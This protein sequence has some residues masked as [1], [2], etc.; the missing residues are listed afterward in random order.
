MPQ[1]V[2]VLDTLLDAWR[3][4]STPPSKLIGTV[5]MTDAYS[6]QLQLLDREVAA[7]HVHR[8]W[9]VG[10]TAASM[11]AERGEA[12]PAPGFLIADAER[13]A[14]P[15]LDIVGQSGWNLEPEL[16]LTIGTPLGAEKVTREAA[17]EAVATA[18]AAFE[19]VHRRSGWE[20]RALQR[21]VN[22]TTSGFILGPQSELVPTPDEVDDAQV[23]YARNKICV[24][25]VRGGDINDNPFQTLAWLATFL[26]S[27]GRRLE[28]GQVVL[29][30]TYA[31]LVPIT[32]GEHW[33]A[34]IGS[35]DPVTLQT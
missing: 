35:L 23:V 34:T 22:G 9:K 10:Q 12:E 30:G 1:S 31:G 3:T 5:P 21:S 26:H 27:H 8:G 15:T 28:P 2:Q 4:G 24:G 13:S 17:F 14:N 20:D 11:R 19:L 6:M 25:E 18:S 32:S 7:G 29:T 16:A 33:Q